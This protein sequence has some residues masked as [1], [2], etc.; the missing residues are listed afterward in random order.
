[1][2]NGPICTEPEERPAVILVVDDEPLIRAAIA[3][4]LQGC[5]FQVI[6]A[7]NAA[8]AIAALQSHTNVDFVF[9]DVRMPGDMDGFGLSRWIRA[10]R[11][12]LPMLITSGDSGKAEAAKAL[13]EN[14][15]FMAKPYDEHKVV[16]HI[17]AAIRPQ[18]A[19]A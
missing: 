10:Y 16:A 6:E 13:C 7:G 19:T 18:A 14:E 17:R 9:S 12:G 3:D 4:Y 2:E 11:P 15:P 1:M 5:G 8:D